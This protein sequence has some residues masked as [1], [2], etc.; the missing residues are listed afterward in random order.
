[1][2]K[3][4]RDVSL[5]LSVI[6]L[7]GMGI[8]FAASYFLSKSQFYKP[9][10]IVN[11]LGKNSHYT[12]ILAG[13][14]RGLTTVN[15]EE[16][17]R[18]LNVKG[19][20]ISMDDTGLPSQFLMIKHYFESGYTADYCVLTLD[21][22][23]MEGSKNGLG[24]NDYR[25]VSYSDRDYVW[26]YFR[27]KEEGIVR[28]LTLSRYFPLFA[29]SYYNMELFWPALYS[30]VNPQFKNRFDSNG[31]YFYPDQVLPE[32]QEKEPWKTVPKTLGNPILTELEE[33]LKSK[34]CKLIVYVAPYYGTTL[35]ITETGTY[36]VINHSGALK[37]AKY[38]F[39]INHVNNLGRNEATALFTQSLEDYF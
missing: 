17:D 14:S 8:S 23:H 33:Y 26:E 35:S 19:L 22:S 1:M 27:S 25:F 6:L 7:I 11:N 31:N 28:P 13:S 30:T 24:D 18:N 39:D 20:N 10:F 16:V 36:P 38:F 21:L 29:F 4:L 37:E 2:K 34:N 32:D 3:F 12:Y 9:N 15:T 5:Y